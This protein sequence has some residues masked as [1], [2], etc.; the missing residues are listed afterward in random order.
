MP[1][2]LAIVTK[3]LARLALRARP[4]TGR[5]I[6]LATAALLLLLVGGSAPAAHAFPH[7]TFGGVTLSTNR[8]ELLTS[9]GAD[10]FQIVGNAVTWAVL[11][12]NGRDFDATALRSLDQQVRSAD[13]AGI[14]RIVI[15][16]RPGGGP[17]APFAGPE[18][19]WPVDSTTYDTKNGE[20]LG[21]KYP[22]GT[23]SYPP[24]VLTRDEPGNTSPWYDFVLALARRYDGT[25]PDPQ[26]PA[27]RLPRVAVWSC[28][29]EPD[30]KSFWYGTASDYF[31]GVGGDARVG[32]LPS[33]YRAVKAANPSATVIG[34]ALTSHQLG[35]RLAHDQARAHGNRYDAEVRAWATAYF[36]TSYPMQRVFAANVPDA[37]LFKQI[38]QDRESRRA[39]DLIDSLF[40]GSA[41]DF[42]DVI[43][44]HHYDDWASL[45]SVI[46]FHRTRSNGSKPIW[47]TELGFADQPPPGTK[48]WVSESD[49]ASWLAKKLVVALGLGVEHVSYAPLL[50]IPGFAAIYPSTTA[51]RLAR[52]TWQLFGRMLHDGYR[53]SD[54]HVGGDGTLVVLDREDGQSHVA[55][56]FAQPGTGFADLG[57]A[58]GVP[59][60]PTFAFD[61]LGR[62]IDATQL[63]AAFAVEPVLAAWGQAVVDRDGDGYPAPFDCDDSTATVSPAV[64]D[65]G[66]DPRD[67]DCDPITR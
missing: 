6:G 40:A 10:T 48:S 11:E 64:S 26:S 45:A 8:F 44:I 24:R 5:A 19:S 21:P 32:T 65:G 4:E 12:P 23:Y 46:E 49:Q 47:I 37:Q 16:L 59:D 54:S 3:R 2:T 42:Y 28:V 61:P 56:G 20:F 33:F 31:G 13:A 34:G 35:F 38:E 53:V 22:I 51:E 66:A 25:T 58:M 1:D 39:R 18:A 29:E 67:N 17:I 57:R 60:S 43:G 30:V 36:R 7:I 15:R 62:R 27:K 14:E 50:G 52:R 41:P 55:V 9:T 63:E